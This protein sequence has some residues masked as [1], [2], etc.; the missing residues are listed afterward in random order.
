MSYVHRRLQEL[1]AIGPKPARKKKEFVPEKFEYWQDES[2]PMST[3]N[4]K[5]NILSEY[6]NGVWVNHNK[7]GNYSTKR[8]LFYT[9]PRT[10]LVDCQLCGKRSTP[11]KVHYRSDVAGWNGGLDKDVLCTGCWN[12]LKPLVNKEREYF[13][14]R[15]LTSKLYREALKCQRLKQQVN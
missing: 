11:K 15:A 10:D 14:L 9:Y 6:V 8:A 3:W 7:P 12:K 13:E 4:A 1:G 2:W 5:G